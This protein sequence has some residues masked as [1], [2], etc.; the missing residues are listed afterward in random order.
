M[1]KKIDI[2]FCIIEFYKKILKDSLVVNSFSCFE[3][4]LIIQYPIAHLVADMGERIQQVQPIGS[5]AVFS[6]PSTLNPDIS[7]CEFTREE[8]PIIKVYNFW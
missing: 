3:I 6:V 5:A 4:F 7:W 2:Y 1:R 8:F